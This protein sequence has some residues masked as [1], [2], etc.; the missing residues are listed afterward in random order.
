M[1]RSSVPSWTISSARGETA[2]ALA[3]PGSP[4]SAHCSATPRFAIPNMPPVIERVL[5]IP[6]K[7]FERKLLTFLTEPELDA[8]LAVPDLTTWTA[9]ETCFGGSPSL[10]KTD[11]PRPIVSGDD[12]LM[13]PPSLECDH[14]RCPLGDAPRPYRMRED[15]SAGHGSDSRSHQ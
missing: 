14:G 6:P 3:T 7:R 12:R 8:L 13:A 15:S 5:A 1:R 2:C 4:R 11:L 10:T 9:C